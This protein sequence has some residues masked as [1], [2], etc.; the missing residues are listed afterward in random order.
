M[1]YHDR[2]MIYIYIYISF[3]YMIVSNDDFFEVKNNRR[4]ETRTWDLDQ[5]F[6]TEGVKNTLEE[7]LLLFFLG[8]LIHEDYGHMLPMYR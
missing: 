8:K 7:F 6:V 1:I 5:H 2:T 4:S 3:F